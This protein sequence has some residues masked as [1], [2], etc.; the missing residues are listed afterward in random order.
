MPK[1]DFLSKNVHSFLKNYPQATLACLQLFP[2]L[3]LGE[4]WSSFLLPSS[5]G[6]QSQ[7]LLKLSKDELS[8]QDGVEFDNYYL[9]GC[10]FS[11][12]IQFNSVC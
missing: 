1:N 9:V 10:T 11:E 3:K 12:C 5:I 6:K 2:C 7:P 4:E 8:L